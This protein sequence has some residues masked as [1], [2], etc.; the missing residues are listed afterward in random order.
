MNYFTCSTENSARPFLNSEKLSP[1]FLF[2]LITAKVA[3]YFSR[4][5]MKA[6]GSSTDLGTCR[7]N[8]EGYLKLVAS[9]L[10]YQCF[11]LKNYD[12]WT[13]N[14]LRLLSTLLL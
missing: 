9:Y 2:N 13:Q 6:L 4:K 12:I 14:E 8:V 1:I 5:F 10:R 11:I 3:I 7:E